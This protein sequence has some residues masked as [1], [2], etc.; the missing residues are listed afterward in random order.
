MR[1]LGKR[2]IGSSARGMSLE[3]EYGVTWKAYLTTDVVGEMFPRYVT[4]GK[5][6]PNGAGAYSVTYVAGQPR[7]LRIPEYS[8]RGV[9]TGCRIGF[10]VRVSEGR[11]EHERVG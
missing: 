5:G 1:A 4:K 7:V 2:R 11:G 10:P 3:S 8:V 9:G 6:N